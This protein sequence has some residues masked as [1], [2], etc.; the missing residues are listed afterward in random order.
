MSRQDKI[1]VLS[2]A[3]IIHNDK[4]LLCQTLDL[5]G[6]FYFL[7]EA[8]SNMASQPKIAACEN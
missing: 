5:E 6:S 1:H 2:R 8:L 7:P 3:A 4:I